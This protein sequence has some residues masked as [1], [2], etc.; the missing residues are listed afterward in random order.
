MIR[1]TIW[2]E[3][4]HE[5]EEPVR[6]IYPK[7]IHE[8][9]ADIYREESEF[10]V[11][12]VSLDMPHQGLD[13]ELLERTDVLIWYG[14][15][16]HEQV[17]DDLVERIKRRVWDGMGLLILH[18]SDTVKSIRPCSGNNGRGAMERDRREGTGVGREPQPSDCPGAEY[19]F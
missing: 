16:V 12:A 10:E 6:H 2:N 17:E 11:T 3:Y 15:M 5:K 8:A 7:G 9:I 4:L 18:S 1:V 19:V 13:T 14:H